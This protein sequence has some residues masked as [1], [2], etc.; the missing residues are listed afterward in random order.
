MNTIIWAH[1]AFI[2]IDMTAKKKQISCRTLL[3]PS[4]LEWS[5]Q[6]ANDRYKDLGGQLT[7]FPGQTE[8]VQ[9]QPVQA[10]P[11]QAQRV[12]AQGLAQ[13]VASSRRPLVVAATKFLHWRH[14]A[15]DELRIREL[16]SRP[17]LEPWSY[18]RLDTQL[19]A[20]V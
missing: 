13:L 4:L 10:Q 11:V 8:P 18:T 12:Q 2:L 17:T 16:T 6:S 1:L 7:K 15:L 20:V 3:Y 9:A 19:R 14:Q 5:R